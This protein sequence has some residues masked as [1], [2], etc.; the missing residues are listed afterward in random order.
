LFQRIKSGVQQNFSVT[1]LFLDLSSVQ[2][3]L[4]CLLKLFKNVLDFEKS[5]LNFVPKCKRSLQKLYFLEADHGGIDL[6]Q[7]LKKLGQFSKT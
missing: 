1:R 3:N 4:S 2:Q 5:M 6:I 7:E